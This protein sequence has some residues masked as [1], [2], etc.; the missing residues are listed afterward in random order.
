[1][2]AFLE[3]DGTIWLEMVLKGRWCMKQVLRLAGILYE[4]EANH[5]IPKK[6]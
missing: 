5:Q 4:R 2:R 3:N 1:M 6:V